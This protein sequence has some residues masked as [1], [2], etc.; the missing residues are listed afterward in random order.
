VIITCDKSSPLQGRTA[1]SHI[2]S[3]DLSETRDRKIRKTGLHLTKLSYTHTEL[4]TFI[5]RHGVQSGNFVV[6][7]TGGVVDG[8]VPV[9]QTALSRCAA[10]AASSIGT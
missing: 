8:A 9:T 5:L 4:V 2:L 1:R 10:N 3:L 7:A 6:Q